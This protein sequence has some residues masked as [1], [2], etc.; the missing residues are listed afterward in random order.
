[1]QRPNIQNFKTMKNSAIL[2]CAALLFA[3]CGSQSAGRQAAA[4][5]TRTEVRCGAEIALLQPDSVGGA[6]IDEALWNRRSSREFAPEALSLEELS[7][8]LWAAAGV[9]RPEN[10]HL[11]APSALA[12]YPVRVYAFLP[13]GV[14]RYEAA[15]HKLVR[16]AEGDRRALA[17]MQP[18]VAAAPL[19]LV[20]VADR[21]VY[22]GRETPDEQVRYLCGQD[23]AGYAENASLYAA[24]HGLKAVTRGSVRQ[25]AVL[26]LLGLD[27]GRHFVALAQSVGK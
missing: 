23:A 8:V 13:E 21:S 10:A 9:N 7:G 5:Q 19:N 2:L 24:G 1:L 17:G 18:F 27:A 3:G 26:E 4:A 12:L 15:A 20:Y 25:E 22:E 14:Y 6:T 16:V 11:T